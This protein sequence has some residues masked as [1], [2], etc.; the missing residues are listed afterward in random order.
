M[1]EKFT[2]AF[3]Q[4]LD[5]V[6]PIHI[7][8]GEDLMDVRPACAYVAPGGSH[9]EVELG[10]GGVP[11]I[12]VRQIAE[13]GAVPDLFDPDSRKNT[14][15][16]DAPWWQRM[17]FA[18]CGVNFHMEHH[19]MASVPCYKLGELRRHLRKHHALDGVREFRGYGELLRH[20]VVA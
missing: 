15:T 12:R 2:R 16:V 18:P 7:V 8:E 19:F 13:H 5:R 6:A 20:V 4:R 10:P 17:I 1:P 14:R 9:M 3:A 11:I